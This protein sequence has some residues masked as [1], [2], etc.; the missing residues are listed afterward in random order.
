MAAWCWAS[1]ARMMQAIVAA[2]AG[3]Q[4]R[5]GDSAAFKAAMARVQADRLVGGYLNAHALAAKLK[6][7]LTSSSSPI[8]LGSSAQALK[9]LDAC[10]GGAFSLAARPDGI[11][12]DIWVGIDKTK[13]P[14]GT[15]GALGAANHPNSLVKL[16]PPQAF[17]AYGGTGVTAGVKQLQ[18]AGSSTS[19]VLGPDSVP[20]LSAQLSHLGD[21]AALE[22]DKVA[23]D[24]YLGGTLVLQ[25]DD[26]AGMKTFLEQLL[27][28]G[29]IFGG[30]SGPPKLPSAPR[31]EISHGTTVEYVVLPASGESIGVRPAFAIS[32]GVVVIG[33]TPAH[34]EQ[35]L[36]QQSSTGG[37]ITADPLFDAAVPTGDNGNF[38]YIAIQRGAGVLRSSLAAADRASYDAKV[39]PDL[40]PL[41][42]FSITAKTSP[43]GVIEKLVLLVQ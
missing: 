7:G 35:I 32:S 13:L 30:P 39:A 5:L 43:D 12:S 34:V 17:L 23:S 15:A 19:G 38:F 24:K 41:K 16:I 18:D 2:D 25:T 33:S 4:A 21:A 9:S 10:T 3:K 22:L 11:E 40:A 20:G 27:Q 8:P 29:Q 14:A 42:A 28:L 37:G 26:A 1:S 31:K 6:D 36:A